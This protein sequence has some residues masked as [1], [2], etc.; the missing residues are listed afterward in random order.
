MTTVPVLVEEYLNTVYKPDAEYVDGMVEERP[1]GE[2]DHAAWQM[3]IAA[4]FFNRSDDWN[5]RV[6]PEQRTRTGP[7]RYRIPDVAIFD[8]A[9]SPEP[10]A[11]TAP[12]LAFEILSREDRIPRVLLRLA[13]LAAMGVPSLYV[14]QPEDGALM[15]FEHGGLRLA[16]GVY[17]RDRVVHWPEISQTVR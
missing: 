11:V 2:W 6:R 17:L 3:A 9:T 1:M 12:L 13:D 10:V 16:E 4:F 7:Q 15:R 5:I 14:V 8:A